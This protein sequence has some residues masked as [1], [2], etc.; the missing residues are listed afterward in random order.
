M[1]DEQTKIPT[2]DPPKPEPEPT[3]KAKTLTVPATVPRNVQTFGPDSL[4]LY[5]KYDTRRNV[6]L[7]WN[8]YSLSRPGGTAW[9][10]RVAVTPEDRERKIITLNKLKLHKQATFDEPEFVKALGLFHDRLWAHYEDDPDHDVKQAEKETDYI[11]IETHAFEMRVSVASWNAKLKK[12]AKKLT[13]PKRMKDDGEWKIRKES[14]EGEIRAW[15]QSKMKRK[16]GIFLDK[17]SYDAYFTLITKHVLTTVQ[18]RV[19]DRGR[20]ASEGRGHTD[21]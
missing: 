2:D 13:R 9:D 8:E 17:G 1:R 5:T 7:T 14:A 4:P 12:W 6:R 3:P 18:E 16:K 10:T 11:I 15:V 21:L 19:D 20:L